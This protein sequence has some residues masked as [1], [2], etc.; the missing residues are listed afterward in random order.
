VHPDA[1]EVD[2]QPI[3]DFAGLFGLEVLLQLIPDFGPE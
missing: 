1:L 2:A 3:L